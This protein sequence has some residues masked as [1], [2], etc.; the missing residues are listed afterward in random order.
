VHTLAG[1]G[2]VDGLRA[3]FRRFAAGMPAT[4]S[5]SDLPGQI[6][7]AVDRRLGAADYLGIPAVGR[8]RQLLITGIAQLE[9]VAFRG[10]VAMDSQ[11]AVVTRPQPGITRYEWLAQIGASLIDEGDAFLWLPAT[12]KN[13]EGWPDVAVVLPAGD[14]SVTWATRP[15]T[16]AYSWAGRELVE[17]RDVLH[18]A[19]GRLAGELR[20]RSIFN[21]YQDALARVLGTELYAADWFDTGSVPDVVLKFAGSLNDVEADAVKARWVANHRDHSPAVVPQ[22]WDVAS[23]GADPASSQLLESRSRGDLEVGRMFGIVPAELLLVE[24]ASST[25][26]YQNVEQ[27]L[28]TLVRVTLQPVYL[29]PIEESLSDLLPRTQVVR[30]SF[31]ELRRLA[32]PEA[33]TTYAAAIGAGIYDLPEVRRKL[34]QPVTSNPQIPPALQPT[35]TATQDVAP[36]VK[37]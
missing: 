2:W 3:G 16:R 10:G 26:T 20:G 27:M 17:G 13:A 5:E 25:L 34:G 8:A 36:E 23:L 6:D 12:G 29:S 4:P 15:I 33:I 9:P 37:V 28:D 31:D 35:R 24:L 18:I 7:W 32:E 14:V 30:F 19:A 22:G 21:Q 1:V 11:P